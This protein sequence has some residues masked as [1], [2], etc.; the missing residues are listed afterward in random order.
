MSKKYFFTA[1]SALFLLI[2]FSC[3]DPDDMLDREDTGELTLDQVFSDIVLADRSL[4]DLYR[5]IPN[6]LADR[7]NNMGRFSGD[8]FLQGGTVYGQPMINWANVWGFNSGNWNASNLIFNSESWPGN[9][10]MNVYNRNYQSIRA[11]WIFLENIENVPFN[12]EFGYGEQQKKQKIAEAKFLLAFF[13]HELMKFFGGVVIVNQSLAGGEDVLSAPRNTY[14]ENV[15]FVTTLLDEAAVDLPVEWPGSEFGRA[16][17]GAAFALKSRILLHAAS[18]LFNDP[19]QP[20]DSPFRGQHNPD[21]WQLAAR[22]AADVIELNK[23]Q[24]HPDISTLYNTRY[25]QEQIFVRLQAM[26]AWPTLQSF[27]PGLGLTFQNTGRNQGTYNIISQYKVIKDGRAY[28][29]NDPDSGWDIQDPY[30]NLDPRFYRDWAFNTARVRG[31]D[32]ELFTLGENTTLADR[33]KSN[34]TNTCSYHIMIKFADVNTQ[35]EFSKDSHTNFMH[36]R[37]AEVL[38]NY[39]EAMN[40]AFGPEVDG[41]GIGMTAR[42]AINMIRAR[43]SYPASDQYKGYTGRMPDVPAGLTQHDMRNEIHQERR[44]E[45]NYEEHIFFD[46]RR[47]MEPVESQRNA[48]WLVPTMHKDQNGDRYYSYHL[49]DNERAFDERWRLFPIHDSQLILNPNLVQNPGW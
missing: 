27:P 6:I 3:T 13:H 7:Q 4:N 31:Y 26:T 33:A 28:N 16:T 12:A 42:N 47:W 20:D 46:L 41:L 37:Y 38:L 17:K 10:W 39:A 30:K 35:S 2:F 14:D 49:Q 40:E 34:T 21:K 45:L 36:L 18:P 8:V 1:I 9:E 5:R 23:Y 15:E 22:A 24:L 44:V 29:Q 11:A 32:V 48:I 43:T 19:N 25:N